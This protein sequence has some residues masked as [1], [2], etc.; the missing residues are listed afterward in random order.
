MKLFE[1]TL[2]LGPAPLRFKITRSVLS[3]HVEIILNAVPG[4]DWSKSKTFYGL[5]YLYWICFGLLKTEIFFRSRVPLIGVLVMA[6]LATICVIHYLIY[7]II[8]FI[9]YNIWSVI[10]GTFTF[11]GG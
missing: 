9:L 1:Y 5:F 4:S 6:I 11:L 8:E 10:R 7:R 2:Y 3:L